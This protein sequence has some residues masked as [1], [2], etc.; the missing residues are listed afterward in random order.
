MFCFSPK[1]GALEFLLIMQLGTCGEK[2]RNYLDFGSS[3]IILQEKKN[4]KK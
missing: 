4:S 2:K 3:E 1:G